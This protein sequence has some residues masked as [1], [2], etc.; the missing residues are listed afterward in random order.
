MDKK[1]ASANKK[2][3][4][5]SLMFANLTLNNCL[6]VTY[7]HIAGVG[8]ILPD[9]LSRINSNINATT[10]SHIFQKFP[11]LASCQRFQPIQELI[12]CLLLTLLHGHAPDL[13]KLEMLGHFAP[14]KC[15]G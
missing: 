9:L 12:S 14:A 4:A 3:K 2:S 11:W 7:A 8:N 10:L 6:G 1:A 13:T 15:I 5:L